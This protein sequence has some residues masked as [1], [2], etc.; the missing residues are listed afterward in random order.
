MHTHLHQ[1]CPHVKAPPVEA[2]SVLRAV[3]H[4]AE[5]GEQVATTPS[6]PQDHVPGWGGGG[7][8][9]VC[10]CVGVWVCVWVG[11]GHIYTL[12][13]YVILVHIHVCTS[14]AFR[15]IKC[16]DTVTKAMEVQVQRLLTHATLFAPCPLSVQG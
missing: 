10:V 12:C 5:V 3:V 7:G 11:G 15:S 14:Q 16:T 8:V 4:L 1:R 9:C 2:I 6:E 13:R